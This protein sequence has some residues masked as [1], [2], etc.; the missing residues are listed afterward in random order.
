[1]SLLAI[2]SELYYMNLFENLSKQNLTKIHLAIIDLKTV[3]LCL[4]KQL[5]MIINSSIIC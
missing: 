4:K 1:M 2:F 3:Q 5:D